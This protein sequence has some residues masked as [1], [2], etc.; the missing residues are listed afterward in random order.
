VFIQIIQTISDWAIPIAIFSI[1]V[2]GFFKKIKVY[3]TFVDGAKEGFEVA[4]KIIPFLVAI[5][6]AVGMFRASGGM[7]LLGKILSPLTSLV[8]YPS[9]AVPMALIRPLSGGGALGIMSE[10]LNTHGPD[11]FIGKLVSTMQGSTDTTLYIIAVYFGSVAIK[12][13][14]HAVPCGLIADAVGIIAAFII[15]SIVF[16]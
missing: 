12:K 14:R 2:F 9:D 10:I 13:N 3:E 11:S 4:I 5:L 7:E 6:V 15:C 8:G 16:K 1:V